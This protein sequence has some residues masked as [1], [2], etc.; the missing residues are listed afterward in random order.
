MSRKEPK[1]S[2]VAGDAS[3]PGGLLARARTDAGLTQAGLAE[4]LGISQAAVAEL[5]RPTSN[6]RIATLDR[7]LRAA[8][9]ELT[10][11]ARPNPGPSVDESLVR[12]Q[13]ALE[14]IDRLRGLE[15]M[16]EQ[17]RELARAGAISRGEPD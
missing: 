2:A 7:A 4:R 1:P 9:A 16:Y 13:L 14:P 6:P 17:A 11:S 12:R 8:G 5:E 3:S 15:M 10:I